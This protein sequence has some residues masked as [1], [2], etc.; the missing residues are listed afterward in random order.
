[1]CELH[2]PAE[3]RSAHGA[4]ALSEVVIIQ[5][6]IHDVHRAPSQLELVR[7]VP[8]YGALRAVVWELLPWDELV[9][10]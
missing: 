3:P 5:E 2:N 9:Q 10:E 6:R 7:F 8:A 4:H 1:M